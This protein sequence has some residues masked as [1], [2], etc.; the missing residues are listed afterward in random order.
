MDP[1]LQNVIIKRMDRLEEK[2]D[3]V[4]EFRWQIA[5]ICSALSVVGTVVIQIAFILFKN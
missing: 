1:I 4:L 5:G 2:L 3:K